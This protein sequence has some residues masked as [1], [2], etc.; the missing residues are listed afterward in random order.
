MKNRIK[1]VSPHGK[2]ITDGV[3]QGSVLGPL[4]F[5]IYVNNL[6]KTINDNNIPI[7]FADDTSIIVKSPTPKDFQTNMVEAFDSVNK[8]FKV[9]S[10]SI[11]VEKTHYIQFKIKNKPAFDINIICDNKSITPAT[12]IKFLGIYLQ[13]SINWSCHIEYIIPK[14]SSACYVMRI[15]RPIMPTNNLTTVYYSHFNAIITYGLPFWGN[16]PQSTKIFKMQKRIVRITMGYRSRVSC[17]SL[18]KRLGILPLTSQYILLLMLFVVKNKHFFILNSENHTKVTRQ[19]NNL[20]N[21]SANLTVYQKG[22]HYMGI[23]IFNNLPPYIKEISNNIKKFEN[24]LKKFL[25]IHSF[26]SLE[27]YFQHKFFTS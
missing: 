16:S 4:L 19:L 21:P 24:C 1:Q 22:A 26:Y 17:R 25:N 5:H 20:Y 18:F 8:W 23:R 14:L 9:N 11:N 13:D 15:I 6:P 10:L 7:L 27:E 3:P 12:D 2:K